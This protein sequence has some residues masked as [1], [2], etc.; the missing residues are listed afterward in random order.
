MERHP[1]QQYVQH[2]GKWIYLDPAMRK[3]LLEESV[4]EENVRRGLPSILK[5]MR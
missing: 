5:T 3:K 2:E 4:F 1:N